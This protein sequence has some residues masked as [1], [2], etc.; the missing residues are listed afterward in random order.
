[1][2]VKDDPKTIAEKLKSGQQL[3]G[4]GIFGRLGYAP[5]DTSPIVW[6]ASV[7]VMA[8]GLSD[9]RHYDSFGVA[10]YWNEVSKYL[11]NDITN[12]TVGMASAK[13]ESGIEVFYDFAVT[14]A[15]RI[16]PGYQHIWNP[17]TAEVVNNQKKADVFLTR[18]T[19]AF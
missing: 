12:L 14:P 11:K 7:G 3:D 19:I 15:V 2:F 4:I 16:I 17:L 6:N 13:N 5:P 18:L 10:W 1:L 9:A 8:H